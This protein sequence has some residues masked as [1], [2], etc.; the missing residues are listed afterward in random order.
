LI[1]GIKNAQRK[2]VTI[3]EK[4]SVVTAY[5]HLLEGGMQNTTLSQFSGLFVGEAKRGYL[6][7]IPN[8]IERDAVFEVEPDQVKSQVKKIAYVLDNGIV[9]HFP[10]DSDLDA[11]DFIEQTPD[12]RKL[13]V[14]GIIIG[15]SSISGECMTD[16]KEEVFV[17]P[18]TVSD[19]LDHLDP[20]VHSFK[21]ASGEMVSCVRHETLDV[22]REIPGKS[23][24]G[25]DPAFQ[26]HAI[27]LMSVPEILA[28]PFP[29]N[30]S[31][32]TRR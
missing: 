13:T 32:L 16:A 30:L 31:G 12:G 27:P 26:S 4:T 14:D 25:F 21:D 28:A 11:E 15:S 2:A 1:R 29:E 3:N 10:I 7:A 20:V 19:P 22:H 6:E 18:E 8:T 5:S 9:V 23:N 17:I 24:E